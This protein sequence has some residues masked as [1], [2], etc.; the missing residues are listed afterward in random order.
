MTQGYFIDFQSDIRR[1]RHGSVD[2]WVNNDGG[3]GATT[4]QLLR[5]K[6][7]DYFSDNNEI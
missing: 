1:V 7:A 4:R 5:F 6:F 3:P 2:V